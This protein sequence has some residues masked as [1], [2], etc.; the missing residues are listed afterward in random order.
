M[1]L[2]FEG[3]TNISGIKKEQEG[4]SNNFIPAERAESL[5]RKM[6]DCKLDVQ[7]VVQTF[8]IILDCVSV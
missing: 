1:P 5:L 6:K 4:V 3:W 8:N 7:P 2:P